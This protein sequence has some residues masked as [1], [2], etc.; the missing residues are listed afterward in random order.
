[1]AAAMEIEISAADVAY[2]EDVL[3]DPFRLSGWL[4][5]LS[6]LRAAPPA[7][8]AAIY[9]RALRA[10]PGSYK[11]WHAYLTELADAARA[12]PVTHR[13]HADVNAAFERALAGGMSRMPRVWH[14][15][16]SWLLH[17]RLL[18]R[19]RHAL[20]RALRSL[21]VTQHHRVWP[22]F[23]RLAALP[24]CPAETALAVYR[25]HLQFDP[26]HAEGLVAFLV[27]AGR[28]R[29]AAQHLAAAI[30]DDG[31]VSVKGTTK[32]Q[33]L[34]DLCGLLSQRPDEVAGMPVDAILCD[35]IRKFPDDAGVLWTCL[36][37]HHARTGLHGKA[38]DVFEEALTTAATV[39]DF[40]MVFDAYLHFEHAM[41]TAELGH[42]AATADILDLWLADRD[43]TDLTMARLE[44]LPERRPELLNGVLLRQNPHD[45]QAWHERA[46]IF[47]KDPARHAATFVEAVRTVDPAKATGK[48]A[49]TL[50]LSLAKMCED[51]GSVQCARDVFRRATQASFTSEDHLAAVYCEFANMELRQQN[52]ETA[53]DIIRQATSIEAMTHAAAGGDPVRMKLHRSLKLW[54]TYLDLTK[55]HGSLDSTIAVYDRMH[56]LGLTT[57]LLV[58]DHA[59]LL[60]EHKRFNDAFRVYERGVRS[61]RYPHAEPIWEA[62]LTK[63]VQRHGRSRPERV[64]DLFEGAVLQA[65]PERKKA[66]YLAYA[67]FEEEF[68]LA[69]RAMKVYE[70]AVTAVPA[71]DRLGVYEV[72]VA[73]AAELYGVLKARDVYCRA[74]SGG[75]LPD[76][77]ARTMC[78]RFADLEV[79]LGEVA[80]A[81]ALY[82]YAAS[83]ADPEVNPDFWTRWNDFEIRHGDES[84]FREMLRV[85]RSM[86]TAAS[87]GDGARAAPKRMLP[88]CA[89]QQLDCASIAEQCKRTRLV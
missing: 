87:T 57:P 6:S 67:R 38:R 7:K 85:R 25:R 74:V 73:R 43:G 82:V 13:A 22:L 79:G 11:L 23:L 30:N 17:Q 10:L 53:M 12:L 42:E 60:E 68:G 18:T 27:S 8:R 54:L 3:R 19:A 86:A 61:F 36:A 32:R 78:V 47:E 35:G 70:D 48:P 80:R 69:S 9:E 26:G 2:E 89:G 33:L 84:T 63:F 44:R 28:W 40:H 76:G 45:V 16:A 15:Y 20:D 65:P 29:D 75:G 52:P 66:A 51:R 64:R 62:Y 49:H 37:S 34:L 41:A 58:L 50:W 46:K 81:R 77:D 55:T 88:G 71:G 4:R 5:Y 39:K 31:F 56:D 59:G 24:G 72:Y 21:P 1:M 14:M 83:F